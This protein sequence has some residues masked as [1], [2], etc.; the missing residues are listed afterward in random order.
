MEGVGK[1]GGAEANSDSGELAELRTYEVPDGSKAE[2]LRML[3]NALGRVGEEGRASEGPG[4]KL[5]V[6]APPRA[7]AAAR[8]LVRPCH[9]WRCQLVLDSEADMTANHESVGTTVND[10]VRR[11]LDPLSPPSQGLARLRTRIA[12]DESA[13]RSTAVRRVSLP[14]DQ[15]VFYLMG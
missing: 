7:S 3:Q 10:D 5:V 12:R 1:G 14:T 4:G 8:R 13:R 11:V 2:L 9:R 6:V 15:V